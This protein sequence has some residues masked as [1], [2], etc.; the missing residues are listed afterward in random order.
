MGK[1]FVLLFAA[2]LC[3]ALATEMCCTSCSGGKVKF[4]SLDEKAGHCGE[5]CLAS[6]LFRVYKIFEPTLAPATTNTPCSDLGYNT[7]FE[8]ETHGVWPLTVVVDL[9][10]N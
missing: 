1:A 4:Y 7:Y 9:Y 2:L 5:C 8:T 10:N 6:Y 3:S